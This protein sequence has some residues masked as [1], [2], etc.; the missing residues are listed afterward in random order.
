MEFVPIS[1]RD[2]IRVHLETN[3]RY[4]HVAVEV[5]PERVHGRYRLPVW[6]ADLGDRSSQAGLMCSTC[7]TGSTDSS[8]D[9]ELS[10]ACTRVTLQAPTFGASDGTAEDSPP[11]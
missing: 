1:L 10:E 6:R 3:P 8:E 5:G 7:I 2:Y 4:T 9:Y 11:F